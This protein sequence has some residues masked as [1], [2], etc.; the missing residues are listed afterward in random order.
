MDL[1]YAIRVCRT[2]GECEVGTIRKQAINRLIDE[3]LKMYQ[4]SVTEVDKGKD[5]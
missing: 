5:N 4:K 2:I 3:V 1:E